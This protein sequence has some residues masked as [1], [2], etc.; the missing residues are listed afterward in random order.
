MCYMC[1]SLILTNAG[2][3]KGKHATIYKDL[4]KMLEEHGA[5]YTGKQVEI[6]GNIITANG[7]DAARLFGKTIVKELKV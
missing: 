6:V 3:L 5:I 1:C 7:P 4:A 2:V